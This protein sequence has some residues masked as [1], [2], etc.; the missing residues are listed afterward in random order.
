MIDARGSITLA[1][2][3]L[4]LLASQL[5]MNSTGFF[6][7]SETAGFITQPGGS[8]GNLCVA[9]EIGRV[10][11]GQILNSGFFGSFAASVDATAIPQPTGSVSAIV[12]ETWHF[13]A[14]FR[15]SIGGQAT[16]N[17]SDGWR[18]TWQ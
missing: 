3:D 13:Q 10:V 4:R 2:N 11:G 1:N 16:S 17:F 12:G 8:T 14:W 6:I 9:G 18:V 15:D 5:P 7:A